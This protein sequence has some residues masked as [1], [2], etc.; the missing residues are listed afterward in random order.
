MRH[1]Y[2]LA[3]AV[4]LV[5]CGG[6]D[7]EPAVDTP[8]RD[9]QPDTRLLEAGAGLLQDKPI[10]AVN[11]YLDGFHF[12]SGDMDGQMEAHHYCSVL[13]EDVIQCVI[14][15]GNVA[16]ARIMGVEYI[17]GETLFRQLPPAEKDLWHSHVYEVRSGQLVAP[18]LPGAAERALMEKLVGTYGKTWHTWHTDMDKDLPYG[19]PQLMM[20][21]TAD[22]Q[23]HEDMVAARDERLGVDSSERRQARLDIEAPPIDPGA[24]A[25][26]Q[27]RVVQL[28]DPTGQHQGGRHGARP[29]GEQ[30]ADT[31]ASSAAAGEQDSRPERT[32]APPGD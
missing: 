19:V 17:I 3:A 8:G 12:Y 10:D 27:G 1:S 4:L 28:A 21:F 22:G 5:A 20:G 30:A 14:Y 7:T 9:R 18:G 25:W 26:K 23:A 13:N 24:D 31:N 29:A 2:T 11:S 16:E 6:G 32:P 15:D